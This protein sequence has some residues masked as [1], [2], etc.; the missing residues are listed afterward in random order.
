MV[1]PFFSLCI[2]FLSVKVYSFSRLG[3]V[4]VINFSYF[5]HVP[6]CGSIHTNFQQVCS[7]SWKLLHFCIRC[8]KMIIQC[9]LDGSIHWDNYYPYDNIYW[10]ALGH[11]G[12]YFH[13]F[14]AFFSYLVPQLF[15]PHICQKFV[16][17]RYSMVIWKMFFSLQISVP[18]TFITFSIGLFQKISFIYWCLLCSL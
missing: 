3:F 8:V 5:F 2:F 18:Q 7:S 4:S 9:N 17:T 14:I 11:L 6:F 16:H 15:F 10:D 12:S 13:F 1:C